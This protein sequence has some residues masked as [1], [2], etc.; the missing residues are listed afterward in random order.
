MLALFL[1]CLVSGRGAVLSILNEAGCDVEER[2]SAV[3]LLA[4]GSDTWSLE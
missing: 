4:E 1:G 3:C 2:V